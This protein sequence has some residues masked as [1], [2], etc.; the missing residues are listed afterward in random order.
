VKALVPVRIPK[1]I[2]VLPGPDR[3]SGYPD[4]YQRLDRRHGEGPGAGQDDKDNPG[5]ARPGSLVRISGS[6]III[7]ILCFLSYDKIFYNYQVFTV[8]IFPPPLPFG[9]HNVSY[10]T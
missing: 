2:L 8:F 3:Q 4:H 1:T 10:K 5:S 6:S 7:K 9:L